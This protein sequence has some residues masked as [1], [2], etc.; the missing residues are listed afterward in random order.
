M[1]ILIADD[2]HLVRQSLC[3]LLCSLGVSRDDITEASNG[4][5]MLEAV[6]SRHFDLALVDIRMPSMDGVTA[7]RRSKEI[8]PD[9]DYYILSG[10]DDFKYAQE[11]IRL[12]IRDYILKP[13]KPA[14]IEA[15]LERTISGLE[16]KKALLLKDL[17]LYTSLLFTFTDTAVAFPVPCHPVLVADDI[18]TK[19]FSASELLAKDIDR[20]I[21]I[22]YRHEGNLFLFLFETPEYPGCYEGFLNELAEQ[23]SDFHTLI[24]GKPLSDNQKWKEEYARM[25][26][27]RISRP[28][29]QKRSLYRNNITNAVLPGM[30]SQICEQCSAGM[31][32][33]KDGDYQKFSQFADFL[34]RQLP[35]A[36]KEYPSSAANIAGFLR[37]AF[38]LNPSSGEPLPKEMAF[39]SSTLIK[40]RSKNTGHDEILLYVQ[41]HFREDLSLAEL[42]ETFRLSPNYISSL[43]KAEAGCN[44]VSYFTSL[45]M[46]EAKRLLLE[47]GMTIREI[48]AETGFGNTSF[49]IR[50]FKRTEGI[51]PT[52]YRKGNAE[53]LP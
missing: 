37:T 17:K 52:E 21:I 41:N 3:L 18:C 27:I 33:F 30:L 50:T 36:E 43:F 22:P 48:G 6:K 19:S 12:G 8:S 13:V 51:T 53:P 4:A 31:Q 47:T 2:E 15:I 10:F 49:F 11:G 1:K 5:V 28:V 32:A 34:G 7:I 35:A 20:I 44:F 16:Q 29:Y 39:L 40:S 9:T 38:Q 25:L 45:R 42:S 24:E 23:Y 14:E 26:S 46:N